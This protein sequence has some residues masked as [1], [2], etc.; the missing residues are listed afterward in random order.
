MQALYAFKLAG[1]EPQH[2]VNTILKPD[3]AEILA[4]AQQ[5]ELVV[6][7][8]VVAVTL[9]AKPAVQPE[10]DPA[11]PD[12]EEQLAPEAS[13]VPATNL[14]PPAQTTPISKCPISPS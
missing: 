10:R 13:P 14:Q 4:V 1:G 9:A 7:Q 6:M 11:M 2:F 12:Q 5:Q 3:L 8:P